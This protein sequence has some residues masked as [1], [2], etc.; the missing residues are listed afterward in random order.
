MEQFTHRGHNDD[1][2]EELRY[3]ARPIERR[4]REG[5]LSDTEVN[6]IV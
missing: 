3:Q 1:E 4:T 6:G 2:K 5:S